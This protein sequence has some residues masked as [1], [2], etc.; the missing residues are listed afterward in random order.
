MVD[1]LVELNGIDPHVSSA[2]GDSSASKVLM[3]Q[4][5]WWLKLTRFSEKLTFSHQYKSV[6]IF[7]YDNLIQDIGRE[8][9][10]FSVSFLLLSRWALLTKI[11]LMLVKALQYY[12]QY[13]TSFYIASKNYTFDWI[14]VLSILTCWKNHKPFLSQNKT[15]VPARRNLTTSFCQIKIK[16]LLTRCFLKQ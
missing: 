13:I 6:A 14:G 2:C 4:S 16:V 1:V 15:H 10:T 8:R 3:F 9:R 7:V 11:N 12:I 5:T